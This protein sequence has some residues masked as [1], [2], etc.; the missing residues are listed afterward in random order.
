MNWSDI[1][2]LHLRAVN[3]EMTVKEATDLISM[4]WHLIRYHL[5]WREQLDSWRYEYESQ[6]LMAFSLAVWIRGHDSA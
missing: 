5:K 1:E 6:A 4:T 3:K 2:Y